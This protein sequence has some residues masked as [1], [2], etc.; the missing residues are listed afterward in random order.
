MGQATE[1]YLKSSQALR[2]I[3]LTREASQQV[4]VIRV[5][6]PE[7]VVHQ[8]SCH[9]V[10][11]QLVR[12]LGK[13]VRASDEVKACRSDRAGTAFLGRGGGVAGAGGGGGGGEDVFGKEGAVNMLELARAAL[14]A[15]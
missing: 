15:R 3:V 8:F 7:S 5:A 13:L 10:A 11:A 4:T 9:R 1:W 6:T 2:A 14:E 12:S